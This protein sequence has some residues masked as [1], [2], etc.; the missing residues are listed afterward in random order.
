[1]FKLN[2][3]YFICAFFTGIIISLFNMPQ[4]KII[5]MYPDIYD[6]TI[7]NDKK[8]DRQFKLETIKVD[9]PKEC[10]EDKCET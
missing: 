2:F 4:P 3:L 6:K 9:C 8:N 7:F 10:F 5:Y 1:M